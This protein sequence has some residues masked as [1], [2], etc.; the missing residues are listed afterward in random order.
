MSYIEAVTLATPLQQFSS[1]T[2]SLSSSN[3][4]STKQLT[5]L[6]EQD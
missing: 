5:K 6:S 1:Q 2:L 3:K 4:L